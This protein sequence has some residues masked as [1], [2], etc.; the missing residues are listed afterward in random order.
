MD[1][2]CQVFLY[3]KYSNV[4]VNPSSFQLVSS[5]ILRRSVN[6]VREAQIECKSVN[7]SV[8]YRTYL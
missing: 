5:W 6:I 2:L 8:G 1:F 4:L 7:F 3:R